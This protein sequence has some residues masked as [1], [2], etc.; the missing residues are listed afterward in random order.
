MTYYLVILLQNLLFIHTTTL[1]SSLAGYCQA[2]GT[3]RH[4]IDGRSISGTFW[5]LW[6]S[7]MSR[8]CLCMYAYT[9]LCHIF[10]VTYAGFTVKRITYTGFTANISSQG[11]SNIIDECYK[12]EY[13]Y[14]FSCVFS[15]RIFI[16][17]SFH[18]KAYHVY[19]EKTSIPFPFTLNGIW[20]W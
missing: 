17:F 2:G 16:Y 3:Y 18:G 9:C 7:S 6:G 8:I 19:T 12:L 11:L 1:L 20:S 14:C 15:L 4:F 5:H 10:Y 13:F